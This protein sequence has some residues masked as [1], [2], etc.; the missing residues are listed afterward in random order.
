[1]T[2]PTITTD[3]VGRT[4]APPDRVELGFETRA[5]EPDVTAARRSVA[6]R[7]TEL[8]RVVVE[9]GA[10]DENVRS[11]RFRVRRQSP[12]HSGDAERDPES[13]PFE[14]MESVAVT[15]DDLDALGDLLA[16]GVDEANAEIDDVTFTFRTET[17]RQLER[18][19]VADAVTTARRKAE[20]AAAAEGVGVGGVRSLTTEERSRARQSG[21]ALGAGAAE[22]S[23]TA[24]AS[25]P[26]DVTVGVTVEY[27]LVESP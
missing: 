7:A 26:I 17:K 4:R 15:L 5:V 10:T 23:G 16:A 8:R 14:A 1:M 9:A 24:P 25:G 12:G 6:E 21:A 2:A 20:A 19:A 27:E 11:T 13:R 22:Q 18:E 3:A